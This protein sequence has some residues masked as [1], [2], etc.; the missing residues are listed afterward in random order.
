MRGRYFDNAATSWPKP[1]AVQREMGRYLR[2]IGGNPGRS[3]HF[4]SVEAG[5]TI[6]RTRTAI[7]E[8][9]GA[10]D[11]ERMVFTK[12]ATEALNTVIKGILKAGD[13]AVCT[14]MEHNSVMRPLSEL[15]EK[16]VSFDV[17]EAN[18]AG[19][20]DPAALLCALR[21]DTKL[22]VVTHASNVT[23]AIND[24]EK[25][26]RGARERGVCVLVDAA[27][28]AGVV[29]IDVEKTGIDFLAFS[30]HKGLLGPQGT[31]ALYIGNG[32]LLSPLITGGTGSLSDR[33]IQPEFFPDRYESG[34]P[35]TV[36]IAGLYRGV[37]H[38][39][40]LGLDKVLEHDG[41]LLEILLNELSTEKRVKCYGPLKRGKQTGVLSLNIEG[42][43][44]SEVGGILDAEY[45][46]QSRIGLHCA[47]RAHRT[48]GTF[49]DGTVRLSWGVFT[50]ER[51]ALF[52]A[53]A[54]RRICHRGE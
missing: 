6:L 43:S 26:V 16:G 35:N 47:P 25:V 13:H 22:I 39:R 19:I 17:V 2:R 42:L 21:P 49:P 37:C 33:E 14:S 50:K 5:K 46:I 48:I 20:I 3:G 36:G 9:F 44:P 15:R 51:D 45:G 27:Q 54:I 4:R 28:S 53:R 23:G 40:D 7:A 1:S 8:F 31:G 11:P 38:I 24:I 29:P 34:T 41:R 32:L 52:T 30:G 12:N 18:A 10:C